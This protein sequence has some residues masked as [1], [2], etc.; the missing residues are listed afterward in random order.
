L[1]EAVRALLAEEDSRDQSFNTRG[2]G[3]AGFVGIVV[4]LS[5][6]LGREALSASW[7]SPWKGIAVGLFGAV[8]V[9]LLLSAVAV[10]QGVLQPK[11][12]SS[13]SMTDVEKFAL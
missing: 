3:L 8:L 13:L 6:T 4:S 7:G 5:A 2:V 1:L 11:E 10:V 9:S 12:A